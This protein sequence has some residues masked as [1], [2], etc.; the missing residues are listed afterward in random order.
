MKHTNFE[1]SL[2]DNFTTIIKA[3]NTLDNGV[4]KKFSEKKVQDYML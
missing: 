4:K 3:L 1:V 2:R